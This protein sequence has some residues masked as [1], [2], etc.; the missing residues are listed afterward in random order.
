MVDDVGEELE[1]VV[2]EVETDESELNSAAKR[3]FKGL[4]FRSQESSIPNTRSSSVVPAAFPRGSDING[5]GCCNGCGGGGGGGAGFRTVTAD[6]AES[7]LCF[8]WHRE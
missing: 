2:E 5:G 8:K 4:G 3:I 6:D 7:L 1:E